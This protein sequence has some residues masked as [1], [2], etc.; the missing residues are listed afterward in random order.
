MSLE[1][2][3]SRFV[4]ARASIGLTAR[5]VTSTLELPGRAI[6]AGLHLPATVVGMG[7]RSYLQLTHF[8]NDL[9]QEGDAV[10]D[11]LMPRREAQPTWATFDEDSVDDVS[12]ADSEDYAI[13]DASDDAIAADYDDHDAPERDE[14]DRAV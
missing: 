5:I 3:Q 1:P 11:T 7:A 10:I 6:R 14:D 2:Y 12:D 9:A 8:I 13:D 4:L